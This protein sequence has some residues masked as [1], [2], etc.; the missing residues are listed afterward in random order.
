MRE[1]RGIPASPG[2]VAGPVFLHR[3]A[4]LEVDAGPVSPEDIPAE[5]ERLEKAL[6]TAHRDL[7]R[8][9]DQVAR[10]AGGEAAAIYGAHLLMLDDPALGLDEFSMAAGSLPLVK[11]V[12]RR[13]DLDRA[14]AA[15]ARFLQF[16]DPGEA[17][18]YAEE[19]HA[20]LLAEPS[21]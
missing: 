21:A 4:A 14:R 10:E 16:T 20:R 6:E 7:E 1:F 12:V 19:L 5:L 3:P 8:I 2:L 18:R 17:Q 15:A 13:L 9:E 11:D